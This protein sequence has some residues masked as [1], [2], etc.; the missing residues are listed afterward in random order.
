MK[1]A[2]AFI[3]ATLSLFLLA[4]T[5]CRGTYYAAWE[6]LGKQKRHLLRDNVEK[7][8]EDQEAASEQ[9]KD[10]YTRLQELY[11]FEGGDLE[12]KYRQLQADY[13]RSVSRAEAVRNRVSNVEQIATDLFKEWENE[14]REIG[15]SQLRATSQ[16][17]LRET[18]GKYQ[19]LHRAMK[20]AEQ[21]ME[22]VLS[23]FRDQVLFLKHNLNAHAIGALRQESHSI[24]A[25]IQQLLR[26]MN[27]SIRE[28]DAFILALP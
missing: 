20:R 23:Q 28:A 13:D 21:S 11:D 19:S 7:T 15:S 9:F 4:S 27:A 8:R 14:I 16:A 26:D 25:E 6:K 10:A 2:P 12:K 24:E 5:G 18:R 1:P 17:Q 3:L 22:P